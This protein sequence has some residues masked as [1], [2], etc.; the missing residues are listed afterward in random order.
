M[1]NLVVTLMTIFTVMTY[2]QDQ[3]PQ[4]PQISVT[5]EGKIKVTPDQVIISVGVQNNG[6]DAAEVKKANDIIIE[7]VIKYIKGYNIPQSD[8]QTTNVNLYKNYDYEKKKYNFTANQTISITL[9]DIKKYD[10]FM[11]DL[12]ETGI[13][14]INGVEFK[15]SKLDQYLSEARKKAMLDAKQKA[16][17]YTSALSLKLGK[18]LLI[19]DNSQ[20]YYPQPVYAGREMM[21]AKGADATPRETLAIGEIEVTANAQVVFALE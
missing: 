5:G 14:N 7:K 6:K 4:V 10:A 20:T 21:L 18:V 13:T 19:T 2:A 12:P 15:S 8:Y 3:R 11:M 1:K 17:D 16:T 9:K